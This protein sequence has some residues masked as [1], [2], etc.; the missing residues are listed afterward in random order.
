MIDPLASFLPGQDENSAAA[1][2]RTLAPLQKLTAA[3]VGIL[4]A[5]HPS[6]HPRPA[7][8]AARGSGALPA[9]VDILIE[10]D[11]FDPKND[12]DRRRRLHAYSRFER[13]PVHAILE[14]N[15]AGNDYLHLGDF[16]QAE[17]KNGWER[18]HRVL[19][20][21]PCKLRRDEMIED[22]PGD[23][24]PAPAD[25]TLRRWLDHSFAPER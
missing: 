7:G 1:M 6:K 5:H 3:G 4:L 21:A 23:D 9:F 11:R 20:A 18:I 13:T 17:C 10:M 8:L 19:A 2:L 22:W 25:T 15:A 12:E 14:L 24:L 16:V